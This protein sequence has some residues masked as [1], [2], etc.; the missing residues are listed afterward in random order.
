VDTGIDAGST[1]VGEGVAIGVLS[2]LGDGDGLAFAVDLAWWW[3]EPVVPWPAFSSVFP[4]LFNPLPTVRSVAW[5]PCL[6]V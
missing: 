4:V 6:I 3:E 1:G 2:G 5:V